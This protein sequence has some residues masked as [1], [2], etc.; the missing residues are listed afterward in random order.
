LKK[1]LSLLAALTVYTGAPC[2]P[3]FA[4]VEAANTMVM[5]SLG[6]PDVHKPGAGHAAFEMIKALAGEWEAPLGGGDVM[7]NIF[8]PFAN[9]TKIFAQEWQN[10]KYITSTIF[11]MVGQELRADH[12]C[13]Y[14]NEPRYAVRLS[15][16]DPGILR[17]KFRS[18]TNLA[19][20]PIHFHSTTWRI[21]DG[22]HFVQDWYVE[23]DKKPTPP[24]RM[25]F[26]RKELSV[27]PDGSPSTLIDS[28]RSESPKVSWERP[29]SAGSVV[30][31][32]RG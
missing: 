18:A 29:V 30:S 2:S 22:N 17:F 13:D 15:S 25:E 3:A 5:Q 20:H 12:Y 32:A 1:L 11:Y 28:A 26:T 7:V 10:G 31:V 19:T 23:G 14:E 4:Q 21:T 9:G 8:T 27:R 16:S 24:I 6:T